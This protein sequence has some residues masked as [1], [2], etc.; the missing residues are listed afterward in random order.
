MKMNGEKEI[1]LLKKI[2]ILKEKLN[3]ILI[4]QYRLNNLKRVIINIHYKKNL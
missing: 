3:I 1:L 4:Y 2:V